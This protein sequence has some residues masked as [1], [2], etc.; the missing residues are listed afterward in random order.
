MVNC[1][2]SFRSE[3]AQL[4]AKMGQTMEVKGK[5]TGF[6]KEECHKEALSMELTFSFYSFTEI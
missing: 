1:K 6:C 4:E 5:G 2:S 3:R